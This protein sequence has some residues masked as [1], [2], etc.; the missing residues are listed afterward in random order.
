M[1][2]EVDMFDQSTKKLTTVELGKE[3]GLTHNRINQ[4]IADGEIEAEK[5]G[6]IWV[7]DEKYIEII[8]NRPE[9]RGRKPKASQKMNTEAAA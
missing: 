4:M 2:F 3:V 6:G 1:Y 7:I 9:K 8:K 5:F